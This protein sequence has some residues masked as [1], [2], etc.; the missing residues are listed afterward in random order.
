MF[1]CILS[2]HAFVAYVFGCTFFQVE[3]KAVPAIRVAATG[4]SSLESERTTADDSLEDDTAHEGGDEADEAAALIR[5]SPRTKLGSGPLALNSSNTRQMA[6]SNRNV[7]VEKTNGSSSKSPKSPLG[8]CGSLMKQSLDLR[9]NLPKDAGSSAHGSAI[10]PGPTNAT[11][12]ASQRGASAD[13]GKPSVVR[14]SVR[15]TAALL[16]PTLHTF[17][18]WLTLSGLQPNETILITIIIIIKGAR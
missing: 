11:G 15:E 6:S 1:Y 4:D 14:V 3:V 8:F 7:A 2:L 13:G 18:L 9:D 17:H 5:T 10:I 12:S 16:R